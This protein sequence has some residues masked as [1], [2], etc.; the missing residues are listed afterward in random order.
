[1]TKRAEKPLPTEEC[2]S[3]AL[4]LS[5]PQFPQLGNW[6]NNL[7]PTVVARA[8]SGRSPWHRVSICWIFNSCF[9]IRDDPSIGLEKE[10]GLA[11]GRGNRRCK[12]RQVRIIQ[13]MANGAQ[14][15]EL[16]SGES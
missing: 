8:G 6:A 5:E 13:E 15:L 16:G 9:S 7:H 12:V 3:A 4:D 1:M 10:A 2:I 11:S 14:R